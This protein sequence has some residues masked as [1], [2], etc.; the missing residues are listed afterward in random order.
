MEDLSASYAY[1]KKVTRRASSSFYLSSLFFEPTIRRNLYAVY[2]FCRIA[3]DIA[4]VS[5]MGR[6][7][8]LNEIELMRRTVRTERYSEGDLLWPAFFDTIKRHNVP[9]RYLYDLLDGMVFDINGGEIRD[10][11]NLDKYS[12]RVAGT[13]G[14]ICAYLL[15]DKPSRAMLRSAETLGL[16]MQYT[17]IIRDV[18][19]D[20]KIGRVYLPHD[21]LKAEG[22]GR[23]DVIEGTGIDGVTRV[24]TELGANAQRNYSIAEQAVNTLPQE[25]QRAIRTTLVLYRAILQ[26]IEHKG[27]NVYNKRIRL[28]LPEKLIKVLMQYR[29]ERKHVTIQQNEH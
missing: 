12:Y 9:K 11:K 16:A 29:S 8:Q 23:Q 7:R 15:I 13:V 26:K 10:I 6:D 19:A 14:A 4:D 24:L 25:A 22:V 2:A 27:F 20:A 17:N 1:C 28:T 21:M 5:S 3:D 18:G